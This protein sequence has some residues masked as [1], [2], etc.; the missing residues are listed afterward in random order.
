MKD[1]KALAQKILSGDK[2]ALAQGMTLVCSHL[3]RDKAAS[4]ILLKEVLKSSKSSYRIGVSGIG[5]VGKSS[6]IEVFGKK[7]LEE[8]RSL[9]LGVLTID[10]SSPEHGGSVLADSVRM[11]DLVGEERVFIRSVSNK[12]T[13]GGLNQEAWEMVLLLEGAGCDVV[14]IESVGTGQS[15]DLI[16]LLTDLS[17]LL[18][19]PASGDG[20]QAIKKGSVEKADILVIHKNDGVLK[21]E[22]EKSAMLYKQTQHLLESVRKRQH[23][24]VLLVSSQE[25]TGFDELLLSLNSLKAEQIKTGLLKNE[26]AEKLETAFEVCLAHSFNQYVEDNK[27]LNKRKQALIG[28][29]LC[30][31]TSPLLG[32]REFLQKLLP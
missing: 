1:P 13:T 17:I 16:S 26:R 25:K 3:E 20:M 11:P 32:A 23:P 2:Q 27:D 4:E 24:P 5:G 22:A 12:N 10:P 8:N 28:E 6:F 15:D 21:K 9:K 19:M 14:I 30:R 18:Q 31:K 29:L 7:L